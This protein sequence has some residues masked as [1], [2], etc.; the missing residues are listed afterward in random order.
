MRERL[1]RL[2][3]LFASGDAQCTEDRKRLSKNLPVPTPH[4]ASPKSNAFPPIILFFH[5]HADKAGVRAVGAE[6]Q[7]TTS[8]ANTSPH[9][10]VPPFVSH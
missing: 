6:L 2:R 8:F 4:Q 7:Q 5:G 3:G 1:P 9:E 10:F